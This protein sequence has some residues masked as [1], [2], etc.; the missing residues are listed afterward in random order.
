[1]GES[2]N[3]W[4]DAMEKFL[5]Q[6]RKAAVEATD[7]G[8]RKIADQAR[9]NAPHYTGYLAS[10]IKAL[11]AL[12]LGDDRFK[13]TIEVGAEYGRIQEEGGVTHATRH[14]F[15]SVPAGEGPHPGHFA[16]LSEATVIGRHYMRD[17]IETQSGNIWREYQVAYTRAM[18]M[19]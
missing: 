9:I 8:A 4:T 15:M 13:A 16:Q 7:A 6:T 14:R 19:P 17:A 5:A 18:E 12:S 1:M 10:T 3:R 2:A 11:P